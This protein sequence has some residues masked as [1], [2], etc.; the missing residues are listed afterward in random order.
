MSVQIYKLNYDYF[1]DLGEEFNDK[2]DKENLNTFGEQFVVFNN[3]PDFKT[4]IGFPFHTSLDLEEAKI[5][6]ESVLNQKL[7][8]EVKS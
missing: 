2:N 3:S 8:W 6:V 4:K 1:Y 7:T 5:Y